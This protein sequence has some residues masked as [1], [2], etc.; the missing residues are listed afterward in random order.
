MPKLSRASTTPIP[1]SQPARVDIKDSTGQWTAETARTQSVPDGYEN[2]PDFL[3]RVDDRGDPDDLLTLIVEVSATGGHG[4]ADKQI[5]VATATDRP[6][7]SIT[8]ADERTNIPT[9]GLAEFVADEER[10]PKWVTY[11][12]D[13]S[14]HPQL[15]WYG[16]DE[17]DAEG[18]SVAAPPVYI[19]EKI[20]PQAIID[21]LRRDTQANGQAQEPSLFDNF[22][23]DLSLGPAWRAPARSASSLVSKARHS[24]AEFDPVPGERAEA[25]EELRGRGPPP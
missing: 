4:A 22:R 12:R 21:N 9:G 5:K 19:Q 10:L 25:H 11:P 2:L 8:H 24:A 17:L 1:A 16:K 23:D 14:T 15:T 6:V 20:H 7:E 13:P 18:L 3:A